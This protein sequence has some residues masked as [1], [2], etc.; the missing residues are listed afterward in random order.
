[1]TRDLVARRDREVQRQRLLEIPVGKLDSLRHT[2]VAATMTQ[3]SS[4]PISDSAGGFKLD[5]YPASV[6]ILATASRVAARRRQR[7]TN[8]AIRVAPTEALR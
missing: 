7:V 4:A 6:L 3:T 8:V 2:P 5:D 1:M